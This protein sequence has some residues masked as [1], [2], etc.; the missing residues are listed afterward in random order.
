L[1]VGFFCAVET[2]M[3]SS[4][5]AIGT[6]ARLYQIAVAPT[7]VKAARCRKLMSCPG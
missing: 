7:E 6:L 3:A 4:I 2:A 5:A 1:A